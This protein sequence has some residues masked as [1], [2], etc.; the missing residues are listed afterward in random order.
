MRPR[1]CGGELWVGVYERGTVLRLD[2]EGRV[3]RRTRVGRSACRV[4]VDARA[5]WVTRDNANELV[6]IDLRSGTPDEDPLSRR[7]ID[8]LLAAGASG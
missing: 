8:V 5:A 6:R 2:R 1:G 7:R 3:T 4:A